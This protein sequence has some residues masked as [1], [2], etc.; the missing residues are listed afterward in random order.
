[1]S[2]TR[3]DLEYFAGNTVCLS[4]TFAANSVVTDV[5]AWKVQLTIKA[6]P[7]NPDSECDHQVD[8]SLT[9]GA[10]GIAVFT[11][12]HTITRALLGHYRYD[13][14]YI[15]AAGSTGSVL[16]GKMVFRKSI[17]ITLGGSASAS[18]SS[19]PSSSPSVSSSPSASSSPS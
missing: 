7:D 16:Y 11:I 2:A 6:N 10:S 19:S 1:M 5:S 14:K 17:N 9:D 8:A 4:L 3:Q 12:P 13:V 15:N 18:V